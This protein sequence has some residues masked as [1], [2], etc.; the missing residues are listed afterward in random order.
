MQSSES[1]GT[2]PRERLASGWG[3][4]LGDAATAGLLC[5]G[6]PQGAK[7]TFVHPDDWLGPQQRGS[8]RKRCGR[9][10]AG[11]RRRTRP[12]A[13]PAPRSGSAGKVDVD[14]ARRP[15]PED[16]PRPASVRLLPE[17]DPYVMGFRERE[18][19]C[20]RRCASR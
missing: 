6:P 14:V 11:T 7:V 10:P 2:A 3:C 19:S 20:R 5:F 12:S 4:Y 1:V 15:A 17:Y 8:R 18:H 13:A 16:A 9:S